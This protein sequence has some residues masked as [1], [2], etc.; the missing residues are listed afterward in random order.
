MWDGGTTRCSAMRIAKQRRLPTDIT[1][2]LHVTT[3]EI[4]CAAAQDQ[5]L[6]PTERPTQITTPRESYRAPERSR[7]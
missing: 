5:G 2:F 3:F 7:N 4:F 1:L 6:K